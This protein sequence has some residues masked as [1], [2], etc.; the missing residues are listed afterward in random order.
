MK[1][2]VQL[3]VP[4]QDDPRRAK[5]LLG[6]NFYGNHFTSGGPEPITGNQ[7]LDLIKLLKGKMKLDKESMENFVDIKYVFI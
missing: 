6:L 4:Q 2:C 3:V 5:I 1:D 7:F